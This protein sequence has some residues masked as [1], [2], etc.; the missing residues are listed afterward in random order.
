MLDFLIFCGL[1]VL[2]VM[3]LGRAWYQHGGR[4]VLTLTVPTLSLV[5]LLLAIPPQWRAVLLGL[6][7]SQR[8]YT[9]IEANIGLV[10]VSAIYSAI[11]KKWDVAIASLAIAVAWFWVGAINSVV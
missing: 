4:F 10:L 5:L 9:T 8:L 11:K 7:Y 2:P 1:L 6:D 3:L